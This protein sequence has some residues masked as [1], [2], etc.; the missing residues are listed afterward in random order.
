[1]KNRAIVRDLSIE[2]EAV[3]RRMKQKTT[4]TRNGETA[5]AVK[6]EGMETITVNERIEEAFDGE[7]NGGNST[8]QRRGE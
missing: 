1:M 5:E 2:G 4:T 6:V 7:R 8:P 3:P